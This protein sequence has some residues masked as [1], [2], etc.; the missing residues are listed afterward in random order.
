MSLD[1]FE[2]DILLAYPRD[3]M[4]LFESMIPIGLASIGA[5]LRDNGYKVKI[6]DFNHY[7]GN[8]SEDLKVWKPKLVGISG[9]TP[10]RKDSFRIAQEVKRVLP[11]VPTVYGGAHATF[12]AKDTLT[13][14]T[15]IDFV[16]KGEG[17]YAFLS[18]ADKI[19]KLLD[20]P[21]EDI[22]GL[23]WRENGEIKENRQARIDDLSKL[24]IPA[25]DLFNHNYPLTLDL[26]DNLNAD[27]IITSRGCPANCNFCSAARMFPGG[28]R[29]RPM[30][31]VATEVEWLIEHKSIRGLK[32]FD[33]TF[34]AVR[35]HV[36]D[37]CEMIK[38]YNLL[39]ECE[40]R[41]D[42]V[43]Y[44]LL[45]TMSEAGCCYINMGL[46]T[47]HE[48]ILKK[49]AKKIDVKQVEDVLVW[50]RN[51][52][53]KTKVFFTFGHIDETFEECVADIKFMNKFK[54]NIDFFATTIGMRVYPGTNLEIQAKNR[55]LI[56]KD[57]SWAQYSAPLKNWL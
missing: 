46:E 10:T 22:P 24:P 40:V 44:N 28:V 16:S 4:R 21:L 41:A 43:D 31:S 12:A 29:L 26:H 38:P 57:F 30:D 6:I 7:D 56:D 50:C 8:F 49:I 36:E 33:S 1:K 47:T 48:H 17:E 39:W 53:I 27:F 35:D 37:F 15:D 45:K 32:I 25:R 55:G 2:Y 3:G 20:I 13:H 23:C 52:N 14:I 42:T 9:T 19:I 54:K 34:T 11:L 18:F 5:V 51:L